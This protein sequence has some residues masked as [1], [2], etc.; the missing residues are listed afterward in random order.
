MIL[1]YREPFQRAPPQ[2]RAGL[3]GVAPEHVLI[4]V[5]ARPGPLY[6]CRVCSPDKRRG[7]AS[8]AFVSGGPA[9]PSAF[10]SRRPSRRGVQ[11][12]LAAIPREDTAMLFVIPS[13]CED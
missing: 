8:A 4:A 5:T 9:V 10:T 2:R 1:K 12:K 11:K 6:D 3:G 13:E 7:D